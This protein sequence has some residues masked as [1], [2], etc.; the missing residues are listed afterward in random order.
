M[1]G[2]WM[3]SWQVKIERIS[4]QLTQSLML[5]RSQSQ[6]T[7]ILFITNDKLPRYVKNEP[8]IIRKLCVVK[9]V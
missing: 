4:Y 2:N 6:A 1:T 8:Y 7:V 3:E 9:N 5:R